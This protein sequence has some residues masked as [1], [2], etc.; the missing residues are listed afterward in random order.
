[1]N[2]DNNECLFYIIG[3]DFEWVVWFYEELIRDLFFEIVEIVVIW[4]WG[5]EFKI[6][7]ILMVYNWYNSKKLEF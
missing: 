3:E 4:L 5:I 2:L 1:M 7:V 6:I